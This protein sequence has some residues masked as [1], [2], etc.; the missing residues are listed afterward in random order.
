MLT[1]GIDWDDI[2][3]LSRQ[4]LTVKDLNRHLLVPDR[5]VAMVEMICNKMEQV[6]KPRALAFCRSIDHAEKLRPLFSSKGVR[7]A[8]L[9]SG[10]SRP[11]RFINLSNFRVGKTDLLI[12]IE[13]LNEGIDIPDVNVVAFMRVTHSRRIF[14]QQ[15]GRGLRLSPDKKSVHVMDFVADI[16][17]IAAGVQMN[18]EAQENTEKQPEIVRYH[19]DGIIRFDNIAAES[20]FDEYLADVA[21]IDNMDDGARLKFPGKEEF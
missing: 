16:R 11:E 3:R 8:V 9:H 21:D 14:L 17:R 2:S 13:M 19:K 12:S 10:L 6:N 7:T 1:D 20:F 15:M 18:R 5:D 4:G